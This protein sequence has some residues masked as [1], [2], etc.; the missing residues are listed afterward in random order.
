MLFLIIFIIL[1]EFSLHARMPLLG[2]DNP[3]WFDQLIIGK[4]HFA[5][6]GFS[7]FRYSP[8]VCGGAPVYGDP[9]TVYYSLAQ[10]L[11][12]FM[13]P[14]YAMQINVILALIVGY[15]G[16]QQFGKKVIGLKPSWSQL[17][18]MVMVA[19]GFIFIH[20]AVGHFQ[21]HTMP[22][23]GLL[24]LLLFDREEDSKPK[25]LFR[26]C[27]FALLSALILNTAGYNVL[28]FTA[29]TA[30]FFMPFDLFFTQD[31][32]KRA[33]QVFKRILLAGT[34][35][36]LI[37]ASRLVAVLSFMKFFPREEGY[38]KMWQSANVFEFI[39]KSFW[40]VFPTRESLASFSW[41]LHEKMIYLSPVVLV[42]LVFGIY[43]LIKNKDWIKNNFKKS[44]F[45]FIYS[46]FTIV[47][48]AQLV[49][50]YGFLVDHFLQLP[51]I[52]SLRVSTRFLFILSIFISILS[53][54]CLS[55]FTKSLRERLQKSIPIIGIILTLIPIANGW[56]AVREKLFLNENFDLRT[57]QVS[58][59]S[60]AKFETLPV[61]EIKEGYTDFIR[62]GTK[63]HVEL[64]RK[65]YP[66]PLMAGEIK[67]D[68]FGTFN[69]MNPACYQYP[70]ENN[71]L[72]GDRIKFDDEENLDHFTNGR[73]VTWKLSTLQ[74]VADYTSLITLFILLGFMAY[75]LGRR[76]SV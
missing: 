65:S 15:F 31:L 73:P 8:H 10:I 35:T 22:L 66:L 26:G 17:L 19:N 38:S 39:V 32:K 75:L 68:F 55:Y 56:Y 47:F 9:E 67:Q 5:H 61:T 59:L 45:I 11:T 74:H 42:G 51:V 16:W 33:V 18:A 69:L 46:A 44:I 58:S 3:I 41:D 25:L 20:L 49:Q 37:C 21:M 7:V 1:F 23:I 50:G 27:S 24:L 30:F 4:W 36:L 64:L 63:C 2:H 28:L 29:I 43:L 14:W 48:L 72:P 53:V 71:C 70:E 40:S 54:I 6:Q 60:E 57:E 34:L 52:R 13:Q 12:L 62:S 76:K